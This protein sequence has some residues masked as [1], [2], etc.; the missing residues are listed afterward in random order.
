MK[1]FHDNP[2]F[3]STITSIAAM[4]KHSKDNLLVNFTR[5]NKDMEEIQKAL[6]NFLEGKW[7]EFSRFFFLSNDELLLILAEGKS[8][9]FAVQPH[10]RKLFENIAKFE[11]MKDSLNEIGFIL[12]A[13]GEKVKIASIRPGTESVEVWMNKLRANMLSAVARFI[14]DA[15]TERERDEDNKFRLEWIKS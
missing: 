2:C 7:V 4:S 9:I 15:L 1:K 13:E 11:L 10:L 8:N 6:E 3:F 14:K 5:H 12:S